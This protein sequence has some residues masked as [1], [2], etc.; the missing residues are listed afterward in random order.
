MFACAEQVSE[1][2]DEGIFK[3][4]LTLVVFAFEPGPQ[5]L[6]PAFYFAVAESTTGNLGIGSSQT[7]VSGIPCIDS[8]IGGVVVHR[9]FQLVNRDI[10][11]A[12]RTETLRQCSFLVQEQFRCIF[13]KKFTEMVTTA[14]DVG[15]RV[16]RSHCKA[17]EMLF[18]DATRAPATTG[19]GLYS[20]SG[21]LILRRSI[22]FVTA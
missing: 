3:L 1:G 2:G 6:A 17:G 5:A 7:T 13:V 10:L 15:F 22:S 11:A 20:F 8:S 14:S 19:F 18:P 9:C 21:R 4:L 12:K 16:N